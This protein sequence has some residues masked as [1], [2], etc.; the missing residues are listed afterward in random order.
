MRIAVIGTGGV[1][2]TFGGALAK[3]GGDVVFVARGAHLDSIRSRGLRIEGDRGTTVIAPAQATDDPR[4]I[5]TVDIVLFCV[6]LWDVEAA[7]RQ[8]KPII[9]PGTAVI[10]LQNGIDAPDRLVPILGNSAVMAGTVSVSATIAEPGVI[11]QT[12]TVMS[13]AFGERDGKSS[14]RGQRFLALAQRSGFD[15][16]L[17]DAIDT[18]IW[19]KF[20]LLTG[21]S[22]VTAL[23]RQPIGKLIG[24]P[25]IAALFHD[26]MTE[27]ASVGRAHGVALPEAVV[28]DRMAA[29]RATPPG[30]MASMAHDLLR[31]NRLEL[32]WLAGKVVELG[33]RYGIAT[34][35][36]AAI[37]AGLKPYVGGRPQ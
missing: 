17:T 14:P 25:D 31:G 22:G 37:L 8:I 15:V 20:I 10:P 32:P 26:V 7:A 13:M 3:A 27:T 29:V 12:G 4:T 28:E 19:T 35:T 16:V 21:V 30:V 24:D 23:T 36:N 2:G 11:R 34:P 9:G 1:G 5:G 18:A 6:K 33:R